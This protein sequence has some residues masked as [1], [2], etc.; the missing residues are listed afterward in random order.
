M[1]F[2]KCFIQKSRE[3]TTVERFVPAPY[4]RKD[5]TLNRAASEARILVCGLGFYEL[6]VN[7]KNVTKGLLAPYISN[8]DAIVYYDEYDV[9]SEL[10]VGKNVIAVVLGN[11]FLNNPGGNVWWFDKAPY[12]DAPK[13]ALSLDVD[14]KRII[15]SDESFV[16]ADSPIVFD[17]YRMGEHYDARSEI[18]GWNEVGFDSGSWQNAI[19]AAPPKGEPRLCEAEPIRV[20]KEMKPECFYKQNGGWIYKFPEN[21][22]GVCRLK[23]KG[24]SGQKITLTHAEVVDENG[25]SIRNLTFGDRSPAMMHKDVYVCG[26][27]G[28]EEFTP[29][30]TYHGFQYVFVEGITDAQATSELLTYIVFHSDVKSAG[31]FDCSDG[32][33]NKIQEIIRRSDESNFHYFPTDCP[34]REKNGWT[35][36][37]ALSAE[38]IMLNYSAEK[39][40]C[41]WLNNLRAQQMDSGAVY[42]IIPTSGWGEIGGP[43]W[44]AALIQVAYHVYKYTGDDRVLRDNVGA[45]RKY[46]R[47]ART[48]INENG[49]FSYGLGDWVQPGRPA[50]NPTTP[51]E[52]TNSLS[53]LDSCNKTLLIMDAIKDYEDREF[54]LEFMGYIK[55]RFREVYVQDG[56]IKPPFDTQTAVSMAIY[57]GIFDSDELPIA[58]NQLVSL[59]RASGDHLDVGV[60]GSRVIFRVLSKYGYADLAYKMI[61][62]KTHPSYA[63][64]VISG[65]ATTLWELFVDVDDRGRPKTGGFSSLNHHFWGD[66]SAWFYKYLCGINV[67]P[68]LKDPLV[69][70]IDPKFVSGIDY[71]RAER[72]YLG[73]K[74]GVEWKRVDGEIAVTVTAPSK[75]KII[76]K[77]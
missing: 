49:L 58:L 21:N 5:F 55:K 37:I 11:G 74:I 67:N 66:V 31:C 29:R 63:N 51:K 22:A 61:S 23:I 27:E 72:E 33:L 38:Q 14:G 64:Q 25:I 3:F 10:V 46:L 54:V 30:F 19:I 26:G 69:I 12:R 50:S 48:R 73:E 7:G 17:D 4:F 9:T 35:G 32:V 57:E 2:P 43:S 62:N 28:E 76:K 44:D 8:P 13:L 75:F 52:I 42:D 68:Q 53:L 1:N 59:V 65:K 20:E 71:A 77:Y 6:Y 34:Q 39:S 24:E 36:D 41:E 45:I 40:F 15:E 60:L 16:C 56:A 18:S 70:E 47:Y